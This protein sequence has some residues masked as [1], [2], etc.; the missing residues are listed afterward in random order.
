MTARFVV[1]SDTHFRVPGSVN[2]DKTFWNRV[3]RTRIGEVGEC[4]VDTINQLA[5]DFV[6]HCGDVTGLCEMRNWDFACSL[7]DRLDCPWFA[8]LGNHDTWF[9]GVRDAF[10]ARFGRA[11][12]RCFYRRDLGGLRFLFLDTAHWYGR[13]GQVS[14]YLDKD[15]YDRGKIVGMGP[16]DAHLDWLEDQL[17]TSQNMLVALVTHPPLGYRARYPASTLPKG[18]PADAGGESLEDYFG[19]VVHGEAMRGMMRRHG[20]V[21]IVFSGHWHIFDRVMQDGVVHCQTGSMREYPFEM[22]LVTIRR[23]RLE[24]ETVPLRSQDFQT[25]SLIPEWHNEWVAGTAGDRTFSVALL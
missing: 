21:R 9:P 3:L 7:L 15:L 6:V 13:E 23:D 4:L 1:I 24:V 18:E 20:N 11:R 16:S 14:P 19:P 8:V 17:A 25:A 10:A 5:P 12:G 22:R 2:E